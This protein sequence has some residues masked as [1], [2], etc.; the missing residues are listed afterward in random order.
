M[1]LSEGPADYLKLPPSSVAEGVVTNPPYVR[2]REF[3]EKALTEVRYVA[4][5]RTN[6][7]FEGS[8]HTELLEE[9]HPPTR[10]WM[11]DVRLPMMHRAGWTEK[12]SASNTLTAGRFGTNGR[13]RA[14]FRADSIGERSARYRNGGAG[15]EPDRRLP[16]EVSVS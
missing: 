11:T 10:I 6:F 16:N 12:A 1:L 2:A 13:I 9:R 8:A 5:V 3:L 7:L 14:S 15:F 4:L